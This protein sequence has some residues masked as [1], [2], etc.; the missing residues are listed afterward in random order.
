[1]LLLKGCP[2][3]R[4]DLMLIRYRGEHTLNCLQCGYAG[5]LAPA[6]ARPSA[7]DATAPRQRN[8]SAGRPRAP[9][10]A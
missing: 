2:R 8:A 5:A 6:R 10:T 3:C 7:A 9:R 1:M 4:G